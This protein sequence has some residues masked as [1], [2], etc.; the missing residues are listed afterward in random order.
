MPIP[1]SFDATKL[2]DTSILC[3]NVLSNP[4]DFVFDRLGSMFLKML[5]V[6]L[7]LRVTACF[8]LGYSTEEEIIDKEAGLLAQQ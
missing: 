4:V 3:T 6:F 2:F 1:D 8:L 7:V 5:R